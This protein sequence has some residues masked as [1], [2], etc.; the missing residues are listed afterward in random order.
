MKSGNASALLVIS[1]GN[2]NTVLGL[3]R[4]GEIVRRVAVPTHAPVP[5]LG[6]LLARLVRTSDA[7][8]VALVSVVP[9]ENARWRRLCRAAGLRDFRVLD[10]RADWGLGID[11]PAPATLGADRLANAAAAAARWRPPLIVIDIGTAATFDA[12]V[13][14]RGFIGGV[15]AP[16]PSVMSDYLSDRTAKLPRVRLRSGPFRLGASTASAIRAGITAGYR[17]L[18]AGIIREMRRI[19]ALRRARIVGAGGAARW[20]L[21]DVPDVVFESDLTLLGAARAAGRIPR[22]A[23]AGG[24]EQVTTGPA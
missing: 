16:G 7:S 20:A 12:V 6:R 11:Y 18:A 2:T 4:G 8:A 21:R 23:G 9:A 5:R 22:P 14:R 24:A 19:P 13:P 1:V 10:H 3:W 17:G 15:I